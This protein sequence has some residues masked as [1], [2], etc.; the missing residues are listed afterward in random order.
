MEGGGGGGSS[1]GVVT[2]EAGSSTVAYPDY[3]ED[4]H[5]HWLDD[6]GWS[7]SVNTNYLGRIKNMNPYKDFLPYDPKP[8]LKRGS[9]RIYEFDGV[10]EDINPIGL[11]KMFIEAASDIGLSNRDA[12]E[13]AKESY[14]KDTEPRWAQAFS[15]FKA[16][17]ADVNAV[18]TSTFVLGLAK[19]ERDK[20][21][22]L[23]KFGS[24]LELQQHAADVNE[25]GQAVQMMMNE[26]NLRLELRAKVTELMVEMM[27]MKIVANT[28]YEAKILDIETK[29]LSF[30]I[31]MYQIGGN[32]L[33]AIS[34]GTSTSTTREY[35]Y[36][37]GLAGAGSSRSMGMIS[38]AMS[39]GASG[40]M[41]GTA[42][43]PG[44]GTIIG[45]VV[46]A[47]GGGIAGSQ[48]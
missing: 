28:D 23:A 20:Q 12:L 21:A 36:G 39:G 43:Y 2:N 46:G 22:D 1:P 26:E 48:G 34:G 4:A 3:M 19:L 33:A 10:A 13:S 37:S 15:S 42:I 38:G 40:A 5:K 47:V 8:E 45:G 41:A 30:P 11:Y 35:T 29:A 9:A 27:R 16:L 7:G 44:L 32:I 14:R 31:S 24:T 17:M 6:V 25:R 18:Q